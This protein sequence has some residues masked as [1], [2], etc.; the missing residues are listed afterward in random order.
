MKKF[1]RI[2]RTSRYAAVMGK[3]GEWLVC[4]WLSRSGFEVAILDQGRT[5]RAGGGAW[6]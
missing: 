6:A 2:D 1:V 3:F 4:H 5:T